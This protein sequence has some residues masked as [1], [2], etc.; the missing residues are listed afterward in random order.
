MRNRLIQKIQKEKQER[1]HNRE[2]LF[3]LLEDTIGKVQ[4]DLG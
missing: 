2:F 1:E 4:T 3:R